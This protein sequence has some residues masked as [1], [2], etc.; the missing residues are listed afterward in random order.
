VL[1]GAVIGTTKYKGEFWEC[2]KVSSVGIGFRH[3]VR[4]T[5]QI[6]VTSRVGDRWGGTHTT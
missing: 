5:A 1:E 6:S 2:G 3:P 4:E